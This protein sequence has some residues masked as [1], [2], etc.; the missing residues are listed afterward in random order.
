MKFDR[1]RVERHLLEATRFLCEEDRQLA[2]TIDRALVDR[3]VFYVVGTLRGYPVIICTT[4]P[5]PCI[6]CSKPS[7]RRCR[8]R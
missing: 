8:N 1:A 6:N 7:A 4:C 3:G 5:R 2:I